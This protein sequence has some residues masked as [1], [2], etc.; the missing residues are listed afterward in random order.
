MP[1]GIVI[2]VVFSIT[3]GIACFLTATK[4]ILNHLER[5]RGLPQGESMTQSELAALIRSAVAEATAPIEGE[6]ESL[7]KQLG[8]RE[9]ANLL[10]EHGNRGDGDS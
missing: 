1:I 3:A 2:I 8:A 4:L 9:E 7:K 10:P 5:R 6:L